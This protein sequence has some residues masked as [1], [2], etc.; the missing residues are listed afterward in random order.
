MPSSTSVP[1]IPVTVVGPERSGKT[2]Y[3]ASLY[4]Q[5]AIQAE[6]GFF[7][8]LPD[9]QS[10]ILNQFWQQLVGP[11][12]WPDPTQTGE[13]WQWNL[14]CSIQTQSGAVFSPFGISYLDFAGEH[15]TGTTDSPD[16]SERVFQRIRDSEF[17][18]VLLDGVKMLNFFNGDFT[19]V[20]E[21]MTVLGV[22]GHKTPVVHL[23]LTKW[24]VL[25]TAG[26]TLGEASERLMSHPLFRQFVKR[27]AQ[28]KAAGG[29]LRL[30]PVSS[31]GMGFAALAP[32]GVSMVKNR[33]IYPEPVNVEIPL[34]A[35]LVDLFDRALSQLA[36]ARAA[37]AGKAG[38]QKADWL[39]WLGGLQQ[40]L[41][42]LRSA[43][44]TITGTSPLL[45]LV[46]ES[47]V[48]AL[49]DYADR[50]LTDYRQG[51]ERDLATIREQAYQARSEEEAMIGLAELFRASLAEFESEHPGSV[52]LKEGL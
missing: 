48:D 29:V 16:Q 47:M 9:E 13:L 33:G 45:Q 37:E 38:Q 32:D 52:L 22:V 31:V 18:L 35:V 6:L 7:V 14:T 28:Q 51:L 39:K 11:Q 17:V 44:N 15:V 10:K 49:V 12:F 4:R 34:M 36:Q 27:R 40:R 50:R 42:A 24:D 20:D 43:L 3:L 19:L 21:L 25:V 26:Y 1:T 23:V 46:R 41:P 30:I 2:V 8:Q 5:L